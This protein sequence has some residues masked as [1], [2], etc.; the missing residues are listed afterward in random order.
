[1]VGA[2]VTEA[3]GW[4]WVFF[5]NVPLYAFVVLAIVLALPKREAASGQ[6]QRS[7]FPAGEYLLVTGGSALVLVGLQ[8][9]AL[10]LGTIG[11][12]LAA[13]AGLVALA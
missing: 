13:V 3:W 2:A 5:L 9:G 11:G 6:Q 1:M 4:R 8:G 12:V 10:S 7:G